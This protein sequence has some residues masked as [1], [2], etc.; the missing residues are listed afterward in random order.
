MLKVVK[1]LKERFSGKK[2][3]DKINVTI[4]A[5]MNL[6]MAK[7]DKIN[8]AV[9]NIWADATPEVSPTLTAYGL[10]DDKPSE[11]EG[12][13][14]PD[15]AGFSESFIAELDKALNDYKQ[16]Q[17]QSSQ[18]ASTPHVRIEFD[19]INDVPRVWIDGKY[20]SSFP[21]HG[22]VRLNLEWNADKGH[23]KP[24]H[25]Y[26]EY[27]NGEDTSPYQYTGIGQTNETD[28]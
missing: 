27:L 20:I 15:H 9:E 21:D 18:R 2:R 8:N 22:L 25:Y 10:C 5:N 12:V 16:K 19:D 13:G 17:E 23:I 28:E 14:L 11:I 3:T 26:I 6:L 24:K 4:D 7:L 1:R